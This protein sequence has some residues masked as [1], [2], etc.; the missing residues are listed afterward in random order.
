MWLNLN[1]RE[2]W[3]SILVCVFIF[4]LGGCTTFN[5]A[6]G[7][8]EFIAISTSQEVSMGHQVHQDIIKKNKLSTHQEE[9][10]RVNRIGARVAQVSD[11]QDYQYHFYVVEDD[12]INAFTVPGGNVYIYTGLLRKLPSDDEIAGVLAHE[13]GHC[14]ARHAIKKF[15]AAL[16]YDV[17]GQ[18]V[19]SLLKMDDPK[20]KMLAMGSD[21]VMS[22]VFSAYSRKDEYQAD[23]LGIKYLRLAGYN[24]EAMIK[25]LELLQKESK[26]P[27]APVILRSHPYVDDRIVAAKKEIERVK[28]QYPE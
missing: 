20:T 25:V 18:I 11:R 22:L 27:R 19:F 17:L 21:G 15:Q 8:N 26:G 13:V 24:V 16:G 14:A 6:T 5:T 3:L 2:R 23:Q 7:H 12:Q 9:I 4:C 28:G 1:D 10:A